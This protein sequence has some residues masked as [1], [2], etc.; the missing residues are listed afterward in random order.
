MYKF[1]Y[2]DNDDTDEFQDRLYLFDNGF[3]AY[4]AMNFED[5]NPEIPCKEQLWNFEVGLKGTN[6][7]LV[8]HPLTTQLHTLTY[9]EI[10]H[11][12]NE[13]ALLPPKDA[14]AWYKW[15]TNDDS[16]DEDVQRI[17]EIEKEWCNKELMEQGY[18]SF[19]KSCKS[20]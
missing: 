15:S 3:S 19:L 10:L 7:M 11:R 18:R 9:E 5:F 12:L 1:K 14:K 13:L 20:H 2:I 17:R 6:T 8:V 16:Q 4:V